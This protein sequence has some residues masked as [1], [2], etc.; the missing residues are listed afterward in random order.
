M[1]EHH[2]LVLAEVR[3]ELAEVEAERAELDEQHER[4][5]GATS[6][7]L[8]RIAADGASPMASGALDSMS[9]PDAVLTCLDTAGP[10]AKRDL[11]VRLVK[12][13]R[14]RTKTFNQHVGNTL[15]RLHDQGRVERRGD[16]RWSRTEKATPSAATSGTD[17][18]DRK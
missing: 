4:L 10:L 1:A 8:K 15:D 2:E 17:R 6:L 7:M 12:A 3:E 13:G 14:T 9:M 5:Q 11:M 18:P 16:G